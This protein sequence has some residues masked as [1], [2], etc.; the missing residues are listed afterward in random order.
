MLNAKQLFEKHGYKNIGVASGGSGSK[1]IRWVNER[2]N[3]IYFWKSGEVG[4]KL[5]FGDYEVFPRE[6]I[7]AIKMFSDELEVGVET[8]EMYER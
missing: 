8:F 4:I 2:N 3:G 1:A 5:G 6:V 7:T